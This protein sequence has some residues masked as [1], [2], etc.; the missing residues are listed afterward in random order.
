M[1][2]EGNGKAVKNYAE[3]TASSQKK[4][5]EALSAVQSTKEIVQQV[6]LVCHESTRK[7]EEC[8]QGE[9]RRGRQVLPRN[10]KYHQGSY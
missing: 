8:S 3:I 2:D 7:Q 4:V 5:I 9:A 1:L 6:K 10:P